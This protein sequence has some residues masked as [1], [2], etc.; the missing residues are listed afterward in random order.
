[1]EPDVAVDARP[2]LAFGIFHAQLHTHDLML[3]FFLRLDISGEELGL[4]PDLFHD[5]FELLFREGIDRHVGRLTDADLADVALRNVDHDI[6]LS[7][8]EQPG[9]GRIRRDQIAGTQLQH[10]DDGIGR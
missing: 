4:L 2:Q 3:A 10:F 6:K 7:G 9:N 8:F 1:M 5:T